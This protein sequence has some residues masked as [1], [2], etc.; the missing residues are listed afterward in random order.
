MT[1]FAN[2]CSRL[3]NTLEFLLEWLQFFSSYLNF[4]SSC[5]S[6]HCKRKF[7]HCVCFALGYIDSLSFSFLSPWLRLCT[8]FLFVY[9]KKVFRLWWKFFKSEWARSNSHWTVLQKFIGPEVK[10]DEENP[11]KIL[12]MP[13]SENPYC[14]FFVRI[15]AEIFNMLRFDRDWKNIVRF[16]LRPTVPSSL[17]WWTICAGG[18]S[19][20]AL[21]GIQF[22]PIYNFL[23]LVYPFSGLVKNKK[24][25]LCFNQQS[26]VRKSDTIKEDYSLHFHENMLVLFEKKVPL[27][28][29][30]AK[31][32]F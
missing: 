25:I 18:K 27:S 12:V 11:V 2:R 30:W 3:T 19:I 9:T 10:F 24:F 29:L 20:L 32:C 6:Q 31:M 21:D 1:T 23:F 22:L 16:V 17:P 4:P 14:F 15:R 7:C 5:S 13:S 26:E 28:V 8:H